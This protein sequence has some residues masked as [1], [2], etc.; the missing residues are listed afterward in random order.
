MS[1]IDPLLEATPPQ[2][3]VRDH[4]AHMPV[5]RGEFRVT[6][7]SVIRIENALL[8]PDRYKGSGLVAEHIDMRKKIAF[9]QKIAWGAAAAAASALFAAVKS[10]LTGNTPHP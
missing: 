6:R 3:H 4:D 2:P 9:A 5:T 8:G 7:D 1:T 10:A